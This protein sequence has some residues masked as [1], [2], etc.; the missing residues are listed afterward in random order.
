MTR[1]PPHL[2]VEPCSRQGQVRELGLDGRTEGTGVGG[3]RRSDLVLTS[4]QLV[5]SRASFGFER[6][7]GGIAPLELGQA[8]PGGVAPLDDLDHRLAVLAAQ[9]AQQ[10]A[11]GTDVGLTAGIGFDGLSPPAD[12][13][14]HVIELGG[15]A[16]E[17]AGGL[18]EGPAPVDDGSRPGQGIH[19]ASLAGE[20]LCRHGRRLLVTG[21]V[22]QHVGLLLETDI[23]LRVVQRRRLELVHLEAEQ[24]DLTGAL[25]FVSSEVG[26]AAVDVDHGLAGGAQGIEVDAPVT[27]EGAALHRWRQ[28]RLVVVL[29]ME[30]DQ[31]APPLAQLGQGGEVAVDVAT[32]PT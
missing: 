16:V 3:A 17:P 25:A 13:G 23:L 24:V 5:P 30:V 15:H 6:R 27:V 32:R 22:S 29:A 20:G 14:G 31:A 12:V 19:G 10:L 21:G 4:G 18:G 11:A 9:L 7:G 2:D 1:R 8:L 28:Q 26:E